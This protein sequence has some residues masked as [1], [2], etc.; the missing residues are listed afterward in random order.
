MGKN[1]LFMLSS[2]GVFND[3]KFQLNLEDY[4]LLCFKVAKDILEKV[5]DG[6]TAYIGYDGDSFNDKAPICYL[7]L[8]VLYHLL[9]SDKNI[10]VQ[11]IVC[12]FGEWIG[13]AILEDQE[14]NIRN[15][16]VKYGNK[17]ISKNILGIVK[18]LNTNIQNTNIV[19]VKRMVVNNKKLVETIKLSYTEVGGDEDEEIEE[20]VPGKEYQ[21][22]INYGHSCTPRKQT[23]GNPLDVKKL[24]DNAAASCIDVTDLKIYK[25]INT[26]ECTGK[27]PTF[28]DGRSDCYGGYTEDAQGTKQLVGST[29][30]WKLYLD[31]IGVGDEPNKFQNVYYYPVWLNDVKTYE[32][33]ITEQIGKA[34]QS[35]LFNV[36]VIQIL[37]FVKQTTS[38]S[39]GSRK[40]K[41]FIKKKSKRR[42]KSKK[43]LSKSRRLKKGKKRSRRKN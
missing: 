16:F 36:R 37:G 21:I 33:S 14:P 26:A 10:T 24:K 1:K 23:D 8:T 15:L 41:R 6:D 27:K 38:V 34:V 25:K 13:G 29:A 3:D 30:G 7:F 9:K 28:A 12:Q 4:K 5:G 40:L 31:H 42:T 32:N 2:H 20:S 17:I 19:N 35:G 22:K 11:P 39:G 43:P 18:N